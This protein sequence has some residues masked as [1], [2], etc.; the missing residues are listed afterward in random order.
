MKTLRELIANNEDELIHRVVQYAKQ[1]GYT[2]FT[3]TLKE[4][5]RVS[6]CG[7]SEPLLQA[8]ETYDKPPELKADHDFASHPIAA[9]GIEQ[10][11]Q[12]RARGVTITLF[13][14]LTKYYRQS[15][16]DMVMAQH[17]PAA[18]QELYRLFIDRFFDLI[19][20]GF[21]SEWS[22]VGES[23]ELAEIQKQNRNITNEK[24]KY[25]TI[26]ESLNDPVILLDETGTIQNINHAAHDL[27]IG[28][29]DPGAVYYGHGEN[30]SFDKQIDRLVTAYSGTGH[31][32]I[33]MET[34]DGARFFDVRI[35]PMLDISEK[36]MGTVL[37]LNDITEHKQ[38]K[39]QAETANRAKSTFLATMSH[40]IRTPINGLMGMANLLND[41]SLTEQQMGYLDGISSSG[42]VL[43]AV[44]N[45]V[46]DYSKIEAGVLELE[47]ID[48]TIK[49]MLRQ[50]VSL[51]KQSAARKGIWINIQLDP[52]VP[53]TAHADVGKI[54]QV[55]LN[56]LSNAI[57]FTPSGE[58][59]VRALRPDSGAS[60]GESLGFEVIDTGIGIPTS[61]TA[62]LFEPFTQMDVSTSRL[63]GG[64][65]LGLA[66]CK[67]II[68]A[69]GGS[70][71][72]RR[73]LDKGSTFS[74]EVPAARARA[75]LQTTKKAA[76]AGMPPQ[77]NVLL[78]E[79][80][81]VNRLVA[82]GFL[83]REG[84]QVTSANSG[85]EALQALVDQD[86]N[87]I[88]MDIRM[89]GMNGVET[90]ERIRASDDPV[91]AKTPIIMLSAHVVRSEIEK[92]YRVG[93]N[94]FLGKPFTPKD[95]Q[96]AIADCLSSEP[97]AGHYASLPQPSHQP[98]VIDMSVLR[99]H[100]DVLG[101]G[102]A[103]RIVST[104]R[105]TTPQ[106]ISAL[107]HSLDNG[108]SQSTE[109]HAHGLKSAAYNVGLVQLADLAMRL[110]QAA[111]LQDTRQVISLFE[112]LETAYVFSNQTLREG[113]SETLS[114]GNGE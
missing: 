35:Q 1:Q 96:N 84:H 79:D 72:C 86:F 92:C 103:G 82:E 38:A 9:F 31:V 67:S 47:T 77:L 16:L 95:L 94:C 36:F 112:A 7:L 75:G 107:R 62:R 53:A 102:Q 109:D 30:R 24:N 85:E 42:E 18:Q 64:T 21:C 58:I 50:I 57:K 5:W 100:M 12:H 66:I 61:D 33:P 37:I 88:F 48:F 39:E 98:P 60:D 45:D 104:F 65:G 69:M 83:Q 52:D 14:G 20:L 101:A 22:H 6:I 34:L 51:V 91:Q 44:L 55:L 19:E 49:R 26:F 29:K 8:L 106:I 110:E 15:Y 93:A 25:L 99:G 32:E 23:Q 108:D 11:K 105:E 81:K 90:V 70:I 97:T 41:T 28:P 4:A 56:L 78:V 76:D 54:R 17:Y 46:L 59:I 89:P 113:W 87:L 27:F 74:F 40:E 71:S 68:L 43:M 3:S 2:V 63:F 13:L 114:S 10:A 80:N 111:S 73:N